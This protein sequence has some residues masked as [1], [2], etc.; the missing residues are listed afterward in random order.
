V[1]GSNSLE[2]GAA[3]RTPEVDF[4]AAPGP[5]GSAVNDLRG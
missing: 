1:Y 5:S 2:G 4:T 3:G